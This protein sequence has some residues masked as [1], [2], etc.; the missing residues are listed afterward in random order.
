MRRLAVLAVLIL[1]V[2]PAFPATRLSV[3]ELKALIVSSRAAGNF[4]VDISHKIS[5]VEMR[6]P[7]TGEALADIRATGLGPW[8]DGMLQ[9]LA[10]ESEF[11][12][13][14]AAPDGAPPPP[15]EADSILAKARGFAANYLRNL[16]DFICTR[17]VHRLETPPS[18]SV[19]HGE[20]FARLQDNDTLTSEVSFVDGKE[21]YAAQT[22]N[23]RTNQQTVPGLTTWGE[24]GGILETLLAGR[25]NPKT[26]WTRWETIRGKRVAVFRYSVDRRN[27]DYTVG[28]CCRS[29]HSRQTVPGYSGE[30][31][32]DP[33][34]GSVARVTMQAALSLSF[35]TQRLD[36]MVE[37]GPVNIGGETYICPVRSVII[38]LWSAASSYYSQAPLF[39]FSLS[40]VRFGAYHKFGTSATLLA[41]DAQPSPDPVVGAPAVAAPVAVS[42]AA[43]PIDIDTNSQPLQFAGTPDVSSLLIT[44]PPPSRGAVLRATTRLVD[45]SAVVLD[46]HGNPVTGLKKEDFEIYDEGKRQDIRLFS[47]PSPPV[48]G[49]VEASTEAS[50]L[51]PQSPSVFSNRVDESPRSAGVTIFLID[52]GVAET[53]DWLFARRGIIQFLQQAQPG[54]RIGLYAPNGNGVAIVQELT[55]D[56]STLVSRLDEWNFQPR[57]RMSSSAPGWEDD[58]ECPADHALKAVTATADHVSGVA[59]RKNLI[60]ISGG[61]QPWRPPV[62]PSQALKAGAFPGSAGAPDAPGRPQ[63][64]SRDEMEALRAVNRANAA[65]YSIDFRGLQTIQPDA[66]TSLK[67]LGNPTNARQLTIALNGMAR[68]KLDNIEKDQSVMRDVAERTGGRAYFDDDILGALRTASAESQGAYEL[69]FYPESPRFDGAYR[70]LEVKVPG[71]PDVTVR[72][73]RGYIDARESPDPEAQLRDAVQSPLDANTIALTAELIA[74]DDGGYDVKLNIGVGD[75]DLR[76]DDSGHWQGRIH[77]VL[78]NRD[79]VGQPLDHR[80]DTLQ[81]DLKPDRYEA[82]RKSG[83]PYHR[84]FQPELRASSLRV[85][86]RDEAGNLGSVTIPLTESE[87]QL[88]RR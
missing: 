26:L 50:P 11:A 71:K 73:R 42:A 13:G 30:L 76:Q 86:I 24:F 7:L 60:W 82:M 40:E 6:E 69:G 27:S 51:A 25:A 48:A 31:F 10:D 45:V 16:P 59:G 23:G 84:A 74:G 81:L 21:S 88:R 47:A 53:G 64:C 38:S 54:D 28:W 79:K 41:S 46:K 57:L 77:V 1:A 14:V 3:R 62:A 39:R 63:N 4:D 66:S 55:L 43:A 5:R 67:D 87:K 33:M 85:V 15:G 75:L 52:R 18:R 36:T 20:L 17:S 72:F 12:P 78:A 70:P 32:V 83:L 65:L 8:T 34:S 35:P 68:T 58:I 80:D 9:A 19:D 22:V 49:A 44:A 56:F 2:V 61:D 29:G 37:Y